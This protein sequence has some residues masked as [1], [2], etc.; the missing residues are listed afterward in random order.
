MPNCTKSFMEK[1]KYKTHISMHSDLKCFMSKTCCKEYR[2]DYNL[3]EH[4]GTCK[5]LASIAC[6]ICGEVLGNKRS[7]KE[8]KRGKEAH[9]CWIQ[10]RMWHFCQVEVI[11]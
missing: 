7:L 8:H 9:G 11:I 6:D 5:A 10:V 4:K 3:K 2:Y 1:S